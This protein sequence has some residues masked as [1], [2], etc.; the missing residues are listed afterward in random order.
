M[1]RSK[2]NSYNVRSGNQRERIKEL[3]KLLG[4]LDASA[5]FD[6]ISRQLAENN[7]SP[8][9]FVEQLCNFEA[10]SLEEKRVSRWIQNAKFPEMKS[11]K[12]FNF[13]CLQEFNPAQIF[14]LSTCKFIDDGEN[15]VFMGTPGLGKTH[16]AIGLGIEAIQ[17]GKVVRYFQISSLFDQIEKAEG[18][19]LTNLMRTLNRTDLLIL[20]DIGY[21]KLGKNG[22][23]FIYKIIDYRY[24]N[25]L[26]TLFISNCPPSE[27]I[28]L[29]DINGIGPAL[30]RIFA[31][32][33]VKIIFKGDSYR[34]GHPR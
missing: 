7:G 16:L 26:S 3:L 31:G 33:P 13:A 28:P 25:K 20:D 30:D 23:P 5:A 32:N 6:T 29:F 22:A 27:W 10:N 24:H 11:L 4:L 9:D 2:V 17:K 14:E 34:H 21:S 12:G 8:I 19:R 15:V 18:S 1:G